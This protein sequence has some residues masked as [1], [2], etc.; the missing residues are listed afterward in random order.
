MV[1]ACANPTVLRLF[2][3]T[4][5][6]STFEILTSCDDAIERVRQAAAD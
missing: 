4:R 5:L 6:D 3:I 1:I 2:E